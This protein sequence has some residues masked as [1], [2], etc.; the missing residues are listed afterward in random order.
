MCITCL[1]NLFL[2]EAIYSDLNVSECHTIYKNQ[3][4]GSFYVLSDL[5][6]LTHFNVSGSQFLSQE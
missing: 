4:V 1:L 2:P 6:P 3:L 5:D